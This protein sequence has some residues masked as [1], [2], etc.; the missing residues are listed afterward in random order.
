MNG[1]LRRSQIQEYLSRHEI[2]TVEEAVQLFQA[3][4]ATIRRDFTELASNGG[5]SRIRGGICRQR[6]NLD[7]LVPFT[8]RE[9]WYSTEKRY[10]A[11]RVYEYLK[12]VETLFIDG[13]STTT[14]LGIFLRNSRQTV[15]TNSLSLC[16]VIAEIF[17]SG[18][19]PE[20][21]CTGGCFH[22]ESGLFLGSH[23]ESAVAE[24]HADATILSARGISSAGIFNHN[25]QIAG[26]NRKMMEHSDRVILIA[27]H[28]KIGVTAMNRV[29]SLDKIEALF[30]L[31][32][33][34]NQAILNDIRSAGVKV[35]SDSPFE[36]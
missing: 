5:V 14:H 10:L 16:N 28:S 34:E 33:K 4:P 25:E 6:N 24:Y 31:E 21:R 29:C 13:G 11:W 15:I 7:E 30:T 23:A 18:G 3:S 19:G 27:D 2:L 22:P 36:L 12:E 8:L 20:I 35:F 1:K 9:K 26:I 17:P 32:T